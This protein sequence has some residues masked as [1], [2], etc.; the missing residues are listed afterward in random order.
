MSLAL[1][2]VALQSSRLDEADLSRLRFFE[3]RAALVAPEPSP[4]TLS[5][6]PL[7]GIAQLSEQEVPRLRRAGLQAF[8]TLALPAGTTA[9]PELE[10]ALHR[11]TPLLGD[12]RVVAIGPCRAS[13]GVAQEH[14][15]TR[16]AELARVLNRPFLAETPP[17]AEIREVRRLL[18]LL[19]ECRLAP[20][21]TLLLGLPWA[22]LRLALEYGYFAAL[23]V[24]GNRHP[25]AKLLEA[26]SRLGGQRLLIGSGGGDFLAVPK[27]AATLEEGAIPRSVR[28]RLLWSNAIELLRVE[29][30]VLESAS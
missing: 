8:A 1:F 21:R 3:V 28:R 16:Q 11:L 30:A 29:E 2:D 14:I 17:R 4:F 13:G 6:D 22:S 26:V 19:K 7:R 12:S 27:A 10:Q 5:T 20:E 24:A 9:G 25:P 15:F 18:S 23:T